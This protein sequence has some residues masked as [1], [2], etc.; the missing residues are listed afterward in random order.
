MAKKEGEKPDKANLIKWFSD[1]NKNDVDLAGVKGAFLAEAYNNK[2]PVPPGFVI[3]IGAY[4]YF[5]KNFS[6]FKSFSSAYSQKRS[7][8]NI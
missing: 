3:T 1:L 6:F 4:K 8:S 5:K 7:E 2:F